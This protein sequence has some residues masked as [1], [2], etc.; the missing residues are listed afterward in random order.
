MAKIDPRTG[1]ILSAK[2]ARLDALGRELPDPTPIA[3]PVGYQRQKPLHELIREMVRSEKLAQEAAE[4]DAGSFDD[5]D[6]FDV[7]DDYDP[8]SPWEENFDP[9]HGAPEELRNPPSESPDDPQS[10]SPAPTERKGK[11]PAA[12]TPSETEDGQ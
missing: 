7:D 4:L 12:P 6:D 1:E 10:G 5:E 8:S 9:L 2:G 3:P 11:K